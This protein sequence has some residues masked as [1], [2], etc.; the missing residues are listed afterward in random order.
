MKQDIRKLFEQHDEVTKKLPKNH[1]AEFLEKLKTSDVEPTKNTANFWLRIGAAIIICVGLSVFFFKNTLD[2][3]TQSKLEIVQQIERVEK[4]YLKNI[5]KEWQ[6]FL[7]LVDDETLITRYEEKL[8]ALN[9][10]Y[11]RITKEFKTEPNNIIVI[12]RLVTNLKTRLKL[13]KD[14]QAHIKF[15]KTENESHENTI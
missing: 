8:G 12:E 15:I 9:K 14:I 6:Q 3:P 5:D 2:D 1:R 10:D 4:E 7:Q 13:L 11:Q